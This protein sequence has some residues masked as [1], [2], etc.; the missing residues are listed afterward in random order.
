MCPHKTRK[1]ERVAHI[2]NQATSGTQNTGKP[3]AHGGGQRGARGAKPPDGGHG[4]VPQSFKRGGELPTPATPPRVGPKTLADPQLT[5]VGKR[6]S[7]GRSPLA[8]AVGV[9]PQSFKRGG[10]LP[11][12]ETRPRAG[13]KTLAN[14]QPTGVGKRGGQGAEPPDGGL[15]GVS[16]RVLKEGVSC[17]PLQTRHEWDPKHQQ[18]LSPRGWAKGVQGAKPHRHQVKPSKA[19]KR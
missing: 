5:G 17:Q 16:P 10:E 11:T 9:S 19:S 15:W 6:G 2:S 14:P 8:G 7:R 13:P 3:S 1:R 4:G 18:T 12:P